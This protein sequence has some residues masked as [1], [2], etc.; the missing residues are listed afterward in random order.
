MLTG[1]DKSRPGHP[2]QQNQ[3]AHEK[4]EVPE[5]EKGGRA[6]IFSSE[7]SKIATRC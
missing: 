1:E 2:A 5:G 3:S 6:L 4:E 7:N